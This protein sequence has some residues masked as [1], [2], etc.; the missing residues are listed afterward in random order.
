[1]YLDGTYLLNLNPATQLGDE[2]YHRNDVT[3]GPMCSSHAGNTR[4]S[5]YECKMV[6]RLWRHCTRIVLNQA[7]DCVSWTL[8]IAQIG[9]VTSVLNSVACRRDSRI[10]YRLELW[11]F[12][13][14]STFCQYLNTFY[15]GC[16]NSYGGCGSPVCFTAWYRFA[17]MCDESNS[18]Y[19]YVFLLIHL[20][21]SPL[22]PTS[23]RY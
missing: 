21:I 2:N 20:C 3:C 18:F 11:G 4:N 7:A 9:K 8:C 6:V 16:P 15:I 10:L 1:L 17:W 14:H 5:C 13:R 12:Q 23:H 19:V 22:R